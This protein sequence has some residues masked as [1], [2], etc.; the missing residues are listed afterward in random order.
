M[1]WHTIQMAKV[2]KIDLAVISLQLANAY[3][4]VPH[5]LIQFALEFFHVPEKVGRIAAA[6]YSCFK[7]RST[8][9]AYTTNWQDLQVSIPM[10]CTI[11]PILF[12]LA[13]EVL[14]RA[15]KC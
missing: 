7:M 13:M 10:G 4:A 14:I 12:V 15:A 5:R 3:G 6:Y 9:A 11:S 8:A 2:D 1:I